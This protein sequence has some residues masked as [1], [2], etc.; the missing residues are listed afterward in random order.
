MRLHRTVNLTLDVREGDALMAFIRS[1]VLAALVGSAFAPVAMAAESQNEFLAHL[2][3]HLYRTGETFACFSR[4][5]DDAYLEAHP[6]Q[7]VVFAKALV[8]A[9]F[10]PSASNPKDGAYSYQ[11]SL[12]FTFR[13]RSDVLTSV[14]E[15]GEGKTKDSLRDGAV[16]AG[17]V[18]SD[19]D[20]HLGLDGRSLLMTIPNGSDLWAPGPVEQRHDTVK[21]PF[22]VD[23]KIFRLDRTNLSQ[24]EDMAFDRQKP[25]RAHEP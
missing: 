22:G 20:M 10:R 25:L 8:A 24:C 3:G 18:G 5:Y 2:V 12:G 15:C 17:P 4:R 23:D 7:D 1:V 19:G 11:V 16:C 13:G 6:Q 21:N 9:Y 14:A